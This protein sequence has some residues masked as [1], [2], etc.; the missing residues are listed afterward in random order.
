MSTNVQ[1][2]DIKGDRYVLL[3][4]REYDRLRTMVAKLSELAPPIPKPDER[5]LRPAMPTIRAII[6]RDII[7]D[8]LAAGLTQKE[9][10][11]LAGVRAET[12]HRIEAGKHTPTEATI[13][14]IDRALKRVA[15]R[16]P[17]GR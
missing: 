14:K 13:E 15:A 12:M 4:K 8:R 7:R 9:L 1:T 3:E 2:I 10:A 5:G 6:A 17:K 16:K 11:K